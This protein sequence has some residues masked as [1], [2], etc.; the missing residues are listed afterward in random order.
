MRHVCG[1]VIGYPITPSTEISETFEAYRAEGQINVWGKHPFFVEA[2]GEHSAQSG[3]LGAALTGGNYVSN[4]SSSQGILY[5]LESHYVTVGKR[6][7]GFVLQVA[8]RVVT[9]HSLNVM[10]GHDDIY[11]LLPSGYTVLFGSSPQEAA[12][13]AAISY[14]VAALSLIP[15]ANTFD[16]FA[17]SHVMTEVDLPE[18]ELLR[19]YLGDPAGHIACPTVAQELLLGA[20]GRIFQLTEFLDRHAA[21]V[22]EPD[23]S[24]LRTHLAANA[25]AI[26]DDGGAHL[27]PLTLPHLPEDLHGAWRR[28]WLGAATK[29]TR[30]RVPALVDP[31]NPGL[32]GPVQNQPDFQAGSADH[33]THFASAVPGMVRQAMEEYAQLTGR[34]YTP[35]MRYGDANADLVMVCLGSITDDIRA[36]L[37]HLKSQGLKAAVVSVKVLQPFPEAELIEAL[38]G[39]KSVMILERSEDTA[40]TR[41]VSQALFHGVA[42]AVDQSTYPGIPPLAVL[43]KITTGIFGLGAHDVQPR[44]L[45]AA[46]KAM[47]HGTTGRLVYIG[48]QFFT[49]SPT[50]AVAEIQDKMRAAYPETEL[51]ALS[52][53]ENP[54][55]LPEGS[56]R[57]RFH[58]VGGYGTVATG[59]L[60]TDILSGLLS[61]NSKSAPKYGS[62]K[63]GA[64]TNY[65]ITLSPEPVL[66]TN[67]ELEDVDV[68]VAPDHR[69]FAHTNPLKGLVRGGTFIMQ[70]DE[71]PLDVWS[72]LPAHA[73]KTIR[74]R[75]I[76]FLVVDAFAVAKAHA[77]TPE[78]QTRMMGIAFIGAVIG[79][80]GRISAGS[81]PEAIDARVRDQ[82]VAKFGRKGEAVVEGNMAVIR[83]G[84]SATQT[85]DYN[86]AAFVA[87]DSEPPAAPTHTAALSAGMLGITRPAAPTALFDR[88]YY[89]EIVARPFREGTIGEAPVLPGTGSFMPPASGAAKDKGLFRRTAPI[90][91]AAK[92]TACLDC[93]FVC[94][95][96]AIPVTAHEIADLL[97]AAIAIVQAP[98]A[99][100]TT[101]L[102]KTHQWAERIRQLMRQDSQA[103]DFPKLAHQAG[104][105]MADDRA[106]ARNLD[107]VCQ[108]LAAFPAARTRPLFDAAEKAEP[109]TGALFSAVVDPWKCTGCAQC[110]EVCGPG[111]LSA[112]DQDKDVFDLLT[113]RFERLSGLPGTPARFTKGA[114]EPGGDLKRVLLDHHC[115]YAMAGGH[116]ACRGCG[117]VT[118]SRLVS[119]ISRAQ[120]DKRRATHITELS[121]LTAALRTKLAMIGEK[122]P[123]RRARIEA[124]VHQLDRSLYYYESGPTGTGPSANVIA[125]S[126]GCSSV[127]GSTL[128]F[129]SFN[130]PWVNSLFQ[131]A[132][133]LAVGIYEG[134]S[135]KLVDEVKALRTASLELEDAYDPAVHDTELA[136]LSWRDFTDAERALLPAILTVS[137]DGAAYDI[138]FGAM[139]RAL[140][141]GTPIKAIVLDTG[142]YSNTGGQASTASYTGQDADLARYGKAHTGKR[143]TRKELALLAAFH[144]GVYSCAVSTA[145][146]G[147]FLTTAA[148]MLAYHDGAALMVAYTPC[149]T[150]QGWAEDQSNARA[151]LAVE[152]RLHPV[153]THDPRRG[154]T[155]AERLDLSANPDPDEPWTTAA[156]KYVDDDGATQIL[157]RRLTPADLAVGEGRFAKQFRKLAADADGVPI[158]EY[159]ELG[160]AAR[161]G[162]TPFVYS[163]D[164]KGR[165]RKVACSADIVFLVEERQNYWQLL[166]F[167]A[168]RDQDAGRAEARAE[169]EAL[170]SRYAEAV[171]ARE[172]S[173]DEIAEAMARLATSSG[174]GSP[175]A[176]PS[177]GAPAAASQAPPSGAASGGA[178]GAASGGGDKPVWLDPANEPRCTDCGTCYQ[179]LPMVFTKQTLVVDGEAKTV[180]HFKE[181]S[182]DGLEVTPELAARI[183]RVKSTCDAEII[184]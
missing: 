73:R 85:V 74:E 119:A 112:V 116:G 59:K 142:S 171:A 20:K 48:S 179:E 27:L 111:A 95:D 157:T 63:S 120:A 101:L 91:D 175:P 24:A 61:M 102:G 14:R 184:Q 128:P 147:H 33:R 107:A 29:G 150:E 16:G 169:A 11:A 23:A 100:A 109:G 56:L 32:T 39:A 5:A 98:A 25:D 181:G 118:T 72:S 152:T 110:V 6:I 70:S 54:Q 38:A 174:K 81:T 114:A 9:R 15:V 141:S 173:L 77:P 31:H 139:S 4:A 55:L 86:D 34:R 58:S 165:L 22:P 52:T 26:E 161:V 133:P 162:K 89:E 69:A 167:L 159:V 183:E 82:I 144:P 146:H 67:A 68:V 44:H 60:L 163:T 93:A 122:D 36:V 154:P 158:D 78:L 106:V 87:V 43:P 170:A 62:E 125:N 21:D 18:P 10:A 35:V 121:F 172:T 88:E 50:D 151:Q 177:L 148:Q 40:L 134:L 137:G 66:L 13:L 2:E 53:G 124:A 12:D 113:S 42:N 168:G 99:Q 28:C 51:M 17:T 71:A 96:A 64:A 94:P 45:I 1:G 47:A 65:Y 155:L 46:F 123:A 115:Y 83:D 76:R 108:A 129:S 176:L 149:G 80:V 49:K 104:Q 37:P 126:T 153:F 130:D 136:I 84:M 160:E 143:E 182:T 135:S 127:Y 41:A 145:L 103:A 79:H 3:A 166:R 178:A 30:L 90:F 8:A 140:A 164:A 131:D 132:Q 75:Q 138:G 180:A 19:E 97:A 92:C 7:G 57:I 156:L 117:E 105:E